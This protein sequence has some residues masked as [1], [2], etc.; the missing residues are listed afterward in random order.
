MLEQKS[1]VN[2]IFLHV[3]AVFLVIINLTDIHIAGFSKLIPLFDLMAVFYFAVFRNDFRIWFI[4]ILGIW[5]DALSG[6]LLGITSLCYIILIKL[7][8]LLNDRMM[9]KESFLQV[10]KQFIG[11]CFLFLALKWMILS[12]SDNSSY[13]LITPAVQLGLSSLF[14]VLMHRFFDYLTKKLLGEF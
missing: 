10:W 8:A 3:I 9:V 2:V 14:Y 12:I 6:N 4:F 5:N 13:S 11:F 1:V 7:F